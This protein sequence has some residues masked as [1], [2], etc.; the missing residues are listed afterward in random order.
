MLYCL[1]VGLG[2]GMSNQVKVSSFICK[3]SAVK[4]WTVSQNGRVRYGDLLGHKFLNLFSLSLSFS[5]FPSGKKVFK[6]FTGLPNN[7]IVSMEEVEPS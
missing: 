6:C 3:N 2:S 7:L 1:L 5:F 4:K